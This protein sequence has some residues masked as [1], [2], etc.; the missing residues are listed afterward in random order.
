M[1]PRRRDR[2][3]TRSATV[4][5]GPAARRTR[6]RRPPPPA[7]TATSTT[8]AG[9]T[10]RP[11][12]PCRTAAARPAWGRCPP[13]CR[14]SPS[15]SSTRLA[16]SA[17]SAR[18]RSSAARSTSVLPRTRSSSVTYGSRSASTR[19]ASRTSA[20]SRSMAGAS[21]PRARSP[22]LPEPVKRPV[23]RQ[24]QQLLLARHV[25]V[26]PRLG[27][28]EPPRQVLHARPVVAA[29]VEDLDRDPQHR[30]QV[31]AGPPA[32]TRCPVGCGHDHLL[33]HVCSDPRLAKL[34][35]IE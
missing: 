26:D 18:R 11:S 16:T 5:C 2:G 21:S 35:S 29:L 15:A 13:G 19:T 10:R 7:P 31:V 27:D 25:V 1:T 30:L 6:S 24:P 20:S 22:G 32:A 14:P 12:S 4:T 33:G 28:A 23:Q 9:T 8:P 34:S 17:S 3:T